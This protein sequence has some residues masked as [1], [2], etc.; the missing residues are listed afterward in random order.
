M[1]VH[2]SL[3][4]NNVTRIRCIFQLLTG[5]TLIHVIN[6]LAGK[7]AGQGSLRTGF[8]NHCPT[9]SWQT[10]RNSLRCSWYIVFTRM[11][12]VDCIM[13]T[14]TFDLWPPTSTQRWWKYLCGCA[15]PVI[16]ELDCMDGSCI[17]SLFAFQQLVFI[18]TRGSHPSHQVSDYEKHILFSRF[19][20]W[21]DHVL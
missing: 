14:L 20:S 16:K 10:W 11:G 5:W 19:F 18:P 9:G 12:Q 1:I 3:Q 13:M 21:K 4:V 7:R 15:G 2:S 17:R 8:G 6:G